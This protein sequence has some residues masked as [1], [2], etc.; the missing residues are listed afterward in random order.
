MLG[1]SRLGSAIAVAALLSMSPAWGQ[2]DWIDHDLLATAPE[3]PLTTSTFPNPSAERGPD[4]RTGP[5]NEVPGGPSEPPPSPDQVSAWKRQL[6]GRP[7][8]VRQQA[9]PIGTV[10]DLAQGPDGR[11]S[12]VVIAVTNG[13]GGVAANLPVPWTWVGFQAG[14]PAITLPWA[15]GD[16]QWLVAGPPNR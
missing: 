7:V 5:T 11:V 4:P 1:M 10:A 16:V 14:S 3:D 2:Q 9:Q 6:L 8:Y 13:R 15:L 12:A